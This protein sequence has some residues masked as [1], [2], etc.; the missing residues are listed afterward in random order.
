MSI[1]TTV[2]GKFGF[3]GA[4]RP[5]IASLGSKLTGGHSVLPHVSLGRPR[6][7]FSPNRAEDFRRE[8]LARRA[9]NQFQGRLPIA[10]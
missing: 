3:I 8:E 5:K 9:M 10:R 7:W 2:L 4:M 6:E 1:V